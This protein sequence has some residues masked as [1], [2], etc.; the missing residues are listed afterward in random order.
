[1]EI[2]F[3]YY[4]DC[5]SHEEA[6]RRLRHAMEDEGVR[7]PVTIVKVQTDEEAQT[8]R[9]TGSPTIFVDGE[10]I[11]PPEADAMYGLSCRVYRLEDG[12]VSPLPSAQMIHRALRAVTQ[13]PQ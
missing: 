2:K 10:D 5:P 11:D 13:R 3:L 6:L 4:E 8:L 9:F 12:R 1:M 7:A